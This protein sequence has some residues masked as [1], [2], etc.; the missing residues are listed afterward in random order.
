MNGAALL[1]ASLGRGARPRRRAVWLAG[2]AVL[3][4]HCATASVA[5]AADP[6]AAVAQVADY[7]IPLATV[8]D[9][10]NER[11]LVES[12]QLV[13]DYDNE[14]VSAVG[15]VRIYYGG[16]TLEAENVTYDER[17]GRLIASGRAKLTDPSGVTAR[18]E[19]IDITDDFRDGFVRSLQV[20]TPQRTHFVAERADR[21]AGETTTFINGEYTAC[22][23]CRDRPEKPPLWNVKAAKIIVDHKAQMVYF[24][25]AR[26]EFFGMPVAWLPY[27]ATADPAVKRKSGVLAPTGGYTDK[28]GAYG[29]LP[30]YWAIAP[31]RDLT[32]TPTVFGRQGLLGEVEW[33]HRLRNGQYTIQIAGIRQRDKDAFRP[34]SPSYRDLRGGIHTAGEFYINRDWTLGWDGTL[35]SDRNF[36]RD[37]RTLN[38]DTS[39]TISTVHLTG[40]NGRN[41]F[42]ARASYFQ[43]L[44]DQTA[45][46]LDDPPQYD[47]G[48]QAIVV[49]VVDYERIADVSPLGG[50]LSLT[51]NLTTLTRNEDDPF[52][53]G[54]TTYTHGVPGTAMRLT[55]EIAWQRQ[56]VGPMGQVIAPFASVRG[57]AFFLDLGSTSA[58][59][60]ATLTTDATAFRAMPAVGVDWSLPVLVAAGESTHIITP[61]A[62]LIARPDEM[63]AGTLPN[64]DAQSLVFDVTNLFD[65]DKF[66]GF[67]RVEGGTR[68]NL[69]VEYNGSFASGGRVEGTFGRS[70]QLAGTNS[71]A[72]GDIADVGAFSGLE[73]KF[74]DYVAGVSVESAR[75]PRIAARGRFDNSTF[76]INRAEVEAT[77][78]LGAVTAST[79]YLYLRINPNSNV[80]GPASVVRNAASVNLA[81]NWRAFG[82]FTYDITESAV[83]GDSFGIAFDNECLTF[84]VAYSATRE[85]YTD[86]APSRWLNFRLQLR[87][88]GEGTLSTNLSRNTH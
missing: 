81:P 1:R 80:D 70:I 40:L 52:M 56:V 57:D 10:Q 83:A 88:F 87:T 25:N 29:S 8:P 60:A 82:S 41:F 67:D 7:G 2:F 6:G 53:V 28:L 77:A 20:D 36:T 16:Y 34:G 37:Y 71:Y 13:Y 23:P 14:R 72:T 85:S 12:D 26:I 48:R 63:A 69:G 35:S 38:N 68:L 33:R 17:S 11:M 49:P 55:K 5:W 32:L 73:T 46:G 54:A 18:S 47:Q 39:E 76:D 43:I 31:N 79:A 19:Y 78:A 51:S 84:S 24:T 3:A 21:R 66:S 59:A 44:T 74:S 58:T 30:Y 50:E 42:E 9:G 4:L 65:H 45:P 62:Q 75:G 64:N 27:F 86:L 61:R 22:E 15:N